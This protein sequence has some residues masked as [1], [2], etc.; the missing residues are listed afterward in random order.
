MRY[1]FLTFLMLSACAFHPIY[2]NQERQHIC[3]TS[4]PNESGYQIKK[5]LNQHFPETNDCH[6][7]LTVNTPSYTYS[8]QSISDKDFITMQQ[9]NASTSYTLLDKNKKVVLKNKVT[10]TG[11]SAVTAS[12]YATVVA[13]NKTESDL[14]VLLAEQIVLHVSAYL[15][16]VQK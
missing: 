1:L 13:S 3:V 4:I 14:N 6:Y 12:P 15:D 16:E 10:T 9:I 2:A 7:T 11:S 8:D 5:Q